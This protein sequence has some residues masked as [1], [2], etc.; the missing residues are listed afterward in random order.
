MKALRRAHEQV[1][2]KRSAKCE[3]NA[4]RLRRVVGAGHD[5]EQVHVA[6]L[7]LFA[8]RVRAKQ[9][10]LLRLELLHDL[11]RVATNGRHWDLGRLVAARHIR[12]VG[13]C[14]HGSILGMDA[15]SEQY[16]VPLFFLIIVF[17]VGERQ[18]LLFPTS[19]IAT[20]PVV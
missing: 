3:P 1:H 11:A 7:A 8:A 2:R 17:G 14:A 13:F 12:R 19:Q 4:Y 18:H 20:M 15:V 10:D 9:D 6:P 16:C 5:D